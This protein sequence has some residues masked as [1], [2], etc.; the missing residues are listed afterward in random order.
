MYTQK[1]N[2]FAIIVH[3]GDPECTNRTLASV[4][5]VAGTIVIIDHAVTPFKLPDRILSRVNVIRPRENSGYGG[6]V[7]CGLG[8][9]LSLGAQASDVIMVMNNDVELGPDTA[10]HLRQWVVKNP[11]RVLGGA[12]MGYVNLFTGRANLA[13]PGQ[14]IRPDRWYRRSYLHGMWLVAHF[15]TWARLKGFPEDYFLYWEDAL[16]ARRAKRQSIGLQKISGVTIT[17]H[18][19]NQSKNRQDQK[20]STDDRLYYLVRN[21]ALFA[22]QATVLPWRLWWRGV[23]YLRYW[24][25]RFISQKPQSPVVAQALA[26][27]RHRQIGQKPA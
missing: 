23:N 27:A 21:G 6:G 26:D 3:F 12:Q 25:H 13:V 9:L 18:Q 17:H 11:D 20:K 22:E 24:Y 16:L 1:T 4:L 5:P 10:E 2:Y 8:V 7:N 19:D 15:A 14:P